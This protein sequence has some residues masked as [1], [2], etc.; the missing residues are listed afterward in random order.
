MRSLVIVVLALLAAAPAAGQ[1]RLGVRLGLAR[2]DVEAETGVRSDAANN[3]FTGGVYF[4][5]AFTLFRGLIGFQLGAQYTQKGVRSE[6]EIENDDL[7]FELDVDY[8]EVPV[9]IYSPLRISGPVVLLAYGG[10]APGFVVRCRGSA[11][12]RDESVETEC[13]DED[14]EGLGVEPVKDFDVSLLVG[15]AFGTQIGSTQLFAEVMYSW[16]MIPFVDEDPL[17]ADSEPDLQHR[18]LSLTLS[19]SIPLGSGG[20]SFFDP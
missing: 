11:R 20:N 8:V 6:V 4:E 13:G 5:P 9:M 16:G 3:G 12:F 15:G 2:G 14:P 7:V 10:V 17:E 19:A 1:S 18:V